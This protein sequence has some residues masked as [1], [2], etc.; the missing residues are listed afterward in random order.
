VGYGI[1]DI[2]GAGVAIVTGDILQAASLDGTTHARTGLA[3]IPGCTNVQVVAR[4]VNVRGDTS[5]VGLA[6]MSSTH[7]AIIAK[8][9]DR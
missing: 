2:H 1:T 4:S 7:I 8:R 5:L 9:I 3:D 6:G